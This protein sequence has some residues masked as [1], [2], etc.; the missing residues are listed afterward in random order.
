PGFKADHAGAVREEKLAA[1]HRRLGARSRRR[2]GIRGRDPVDPE[3]RQDGGSGSKTAK[4][5][6]TPFGDT[7][8]ARAD[9]ARVCIGPPVRPGAGPAPV[10]TSSVSLSPRRRL[11]ALVHHLL[12]HLH[13]LHHPH[14]LRHVLPVTSLAH[15]HLPGP[16]EARHLHHLH[17][18]HH[19]LHLP[20]LSLRG[21]SLAH[22]P[23]AHH[24]APLAHAARAHHPHHL[25]H[26]VRA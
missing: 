2:R 3:H 18:L 21:A 4:H 1:L 14:H 12:H 22:P 20:A 6:L 19:V 8:T 23:S 7:R 13:H 25:L 26:R 17:H 15:R 9:S 5:R 10:L 24:R 11:P 16:A